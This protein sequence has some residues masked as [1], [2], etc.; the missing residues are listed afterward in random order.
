MNE[1]IQFYGPFWGHSGPS[2]HGQELCKTL[3]KQ[4]F[5]V[6]VK[7]H[8]M[9]SRDNLQQMLDSEVWAMYEKPEYNEA[10]TILLD[11]PQTWWMHMA[12]ARKALIGV[13]VLEGSHIPFDWIMACA[14]PEMTQ[15]WVPSTHVKT[16]ILS[17]ALLFNLNLKSLD[18]KIRILPHGYNPEDFHV[19]GKKKKF[20]EDDLFTFIFVGGW[21]QG[22]N[23]RKGLDILY[24]AFCEEFKEKEKVACVL[25]VT[26][27]YN[28]PGYDA[29]GQLQLLKIPKSHAKCVLVGGDVKTKDELAE[30][31]KAGQVYVLPSK[32]EGFSMTTLEAMA[33]GLVPLVSDYGGQLD[34]VNPDNGYLIK[35]GKFTDATDGNTALYD[36]TKWRIPDK[37][38]L[39][40]K[41]R[42]IFT[43]QSELANKKQLCLGTV[44]QWTWAQTGEK[45]AKYIKELQH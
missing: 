38:D 27:I 37:N 16:A 1:K 31:Y 30:I 28:Q 43:H 41:L 19:E 45:A 22:I 24:R 40:K 15:I 21:S 39:R 32:A 4:G 23:D 29:A 42:Y 9:P 7:S 26:Q 25:K 14:Q 17:S 5:D 34:F 11:P 10:I 6:S 44:K 3:S 20:V 13:I 33:C 8:F 18:N 2:T 35:T 12:E 36:W